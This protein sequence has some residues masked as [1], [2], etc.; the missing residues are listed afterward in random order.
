ML[1][2]GLN[3]VSPKRKT[4]P[5]LATFLAANQM[6][7][8]EA[9]LGRKDVV[10]HSQEEVATRTGW[11]DLGLRVCSVRCGLL[12]GELTSWALSIKNLRTSQNNMTS[13]GW[14]IH[15]YEPVMDTPSGSHSK[16]HPLI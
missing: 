1:L 12:T 6:P 5:A 9:S 8:K 3:S 11:Q 2:S 15:M 4:Q 10:Y 13:S 16:P 7:D 14:S